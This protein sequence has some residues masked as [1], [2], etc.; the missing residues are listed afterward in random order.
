MVR[1]ADVVIHAGTWSS[2]WGHAQQEHERFE[3]PSL[4]LID[5]A[6]A[7]GVGRFI[8]ASTVALGTPAT[9]EGLVAE[10]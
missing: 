6:A 5:Q 2:F 4:D 3:T 1:D 8:A 7:A 9:G 10:R